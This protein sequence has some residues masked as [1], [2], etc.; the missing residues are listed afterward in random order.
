VKSPTAALG[1]SPQFEAMAHDVSTRAAALRWSGRRLRKLGL[2]AV[3]GI[4]LTP[5]ASALVV[6]VVYVVRRQSLPP[7]DGIVSSSLAWTVVIIPILLLS[8]GIIASRYAKFRRRVEPIVQGGTETAGRVV[9]VQCTS[10]TGTGG[11]RFDKL[12]LTVCTPG[13]DLVVAIEESQ[14]TKLPLVA[15]GAPATVWTLA[16]K[17]VVGTSGALFES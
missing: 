10:R 8:T 6:G 12:A 5:V 7:W 4:A 1:A 11:V 13:G 14:G 2:I 15:V 17:S 16:G 9:E 3:V